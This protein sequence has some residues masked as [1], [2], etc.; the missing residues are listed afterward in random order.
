MLWKTSLTWLDFNVSPH[1]CCAIFG[2]LFRN[3]FC[4]FIEFSLNVFKTLSTDTC[5]RNVQDLNIH[6]GGI[7]LPLHTL[8][9]FS[10]TCMLLL[11]GM[12]IEVPFD[13]RKWGGVVGE[14]VDLIVI[15]VYSLFVWYHGSVVQAD[16][17]HPT[18]VQVVCSHPLFVSTPTVFVHIHCLNKQGLVLRWKKTG[19]MTFNVMD[20]GIDIRSLCWLMIYLW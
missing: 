15:M 4:A 14:V 13:W 17:C 1:D 8:C 11:N 3:I 10:Y 20:A 7:K 5:N 18:H 16:M 12:P 9:A 2:I 19:Y 6:W